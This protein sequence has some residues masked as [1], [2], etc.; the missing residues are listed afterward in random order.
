[1]GFPGGTAGKDSACHAGDLGSLPGLGRSPGEG[2]GYGFHGLYSPQ[3]CKESATTERLA[4]SLWTS[5]RVCSV[6]QSCL[7]LCD[8]MD[9]SPSGSC[10]HG[11][12]Q[13]RI[14]EGVAMPS[15]RGSSRPRDRTPG[16][17]HCRQILYCLSCQRRS[18]LNNFCPLLHNGP[19]P[20]LLKD[21]EALRGPQ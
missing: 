6:A 20:C 2:K 10:V 9:C 17:L 1:M 19:A 5:V 16:L 15:S 7:T 11:I 13:A 3:G 14:L 21:G 18:V 8:P 12:L 4:L